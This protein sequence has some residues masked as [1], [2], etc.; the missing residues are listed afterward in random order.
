M[1]NLTAD[2]MEIFA[3]LGEA[4]NIFVKTPPEHPTERQEFM[5]AIHRAQDIVL[6]R[7]ALR[8]YGWSKGKKDND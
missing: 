1:G 2:E 4:W 8:Q 6:A 3:K 7:L 5:L